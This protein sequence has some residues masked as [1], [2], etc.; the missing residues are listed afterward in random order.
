MLPESVTS[1][2]VEPTY[3]RFQNR[4]TY[5]GIDGSRIGEGKKSFTTPIEHAEQSATVQI[6]GA[7]G[8]PRDVNRKEGLTMLRNVRSFSARCSVWIPG[9][10]GPAEPFSM[11]SLPTDAESIRSIEKYFTGRMVYDCSARENPPGPA[12]V[13][14]AVQVAVV[15]LY[16]TTPEQWAKLKIGRGDRIRAIWAV[17]GYMKRS[18]WRS[19]TGR[20]SDKR[21]FRPYPQAG[22]NP[23]PGP[24]AVAMA[25]E[26]ASRGVTGKP[27]GSRHE[28]TETLPAHEVRS[29][30]IGYQ[31]E[32]KIG[33]IHVSGGVC[34]V[35]TDGTMRHVET[36]R[37]IENETMEDGTVVQSTIVETVPKMLPG[38]TRV[39]FEPGFVFDSAEW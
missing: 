3:H 17:A 25:V 6:C 14:E 1:A 8:A 38:Y 7:I 39:H 29:A 12:E 28:R 33:T 19:G 9:L 31:R 27:R 13:E 30:M 34:S 26:E 21:R 10:K 32:T 23:S 22:R 11:D 20:R 35:E 36:R 24:M 15:R 18:G 16:T 5:T 37:W 2:S 4:H